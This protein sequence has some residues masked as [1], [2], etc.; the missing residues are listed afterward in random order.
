MSDLLEQ[1]TTRLAATPRAKSDSKCSKLHSCMEAIL[2]DACRV[3]T[4][5]SS[6]VRLKKFHKNGRDVEIISCIQEIIKIWKC[7]DTF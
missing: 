1:G 6:A 4:I 7:T 2:K 3:A 5:P